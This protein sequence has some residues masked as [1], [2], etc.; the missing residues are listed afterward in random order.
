MN[1]VIAKMMLL[2]TAVTTR[3]KIPVIATFSC[4]WFPKSVRHRSQCRR[5]FPVI[6]SPWI[7]PRRPERAL[8]AEKYPP[9]R[10]FRKKK[11]AA[12]T[13]SRLATTIGRA[14]L[15]A[16]FGMVTGVSLHVYSP[17]LQL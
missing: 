3:L 15:T 12:I 8:R 17:R 16:V 9:E 4:G 6:T 14:G 11:N 10:V 5:V 1:R 13:Y 7:R 2:M